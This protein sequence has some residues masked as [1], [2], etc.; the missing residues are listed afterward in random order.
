[1]NTKLTPEQ[2]QAVV[3]YQQAMTMH[4][5]KWAGYK[6]KSGGWSESGQEQEFNEWHDLL[7]ILAVAEL[8]MKTLVELGV[9]HWLEA[10]DA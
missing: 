4:T 2:Q 1:M 10:A 6:W 7:D 9:D 8:P 3:Q 5:L